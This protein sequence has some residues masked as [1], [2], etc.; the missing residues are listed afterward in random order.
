MS[1]EDTNPIRQALCD[2][3]RVESFGAPAGIDAVSSAEHRL[4]V[5]FPEWLRCLYLACDG[6]L[7]PTAWPYLLPLNGRE[8]VIEFTEFLR[9]EAGPLAWL[10]NAVVFGSNLGSGTC[11]V[12][13]GALDGRLI[14]WC[15]GDGDEFTYF[16][17]SVYDLYRREQ[18]VWDAIHF[19]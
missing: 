14:E 19:P 2:A 1:V 5:A 15:L 8:G 10:K 4:G 3:I 7:G 12:H 6:F 13:F 18:A 9:A 11:T 17:G 16:D